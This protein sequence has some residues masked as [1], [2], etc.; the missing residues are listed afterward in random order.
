MERAGVDALPFGP[1]CRTLAER[2]EER[3]RLES[4]AEVAALSTAVRP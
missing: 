4:E 3:I 1:G 2:C